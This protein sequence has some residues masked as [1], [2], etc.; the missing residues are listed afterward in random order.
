MVARLRGAI[1]LG[2]Q[3]LTFQSYPIIFEQGHGFN[4]QSTGAT[5]LGMGVGMLIALAIQPLF[6]RYGCLLYHIC[7][8]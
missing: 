2:L 4:V 6:I 8:G 5:F 1:V 3:Y 7:Y